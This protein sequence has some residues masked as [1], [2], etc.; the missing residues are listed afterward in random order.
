[1]KA[2]PRSASR[3]LTSAVWP[4]T[5]VAWPG[6][7]LTM[8]CQAPSVLSLV[9]ILPAKG[10]VPEVRSLAWMPSTTTSPAKPLL[11]ACQ[12]ASVLPLAKKKRYLVRSP[13]RM[14]P[15]GPP[16]LPTP[17]GPV[18]QSAGTSTRT[19]FCRSIEAVANTPA[20]TV[21]LFSPAASVTTWLMPV[22]VLASESEA[23]LPR[24]AVV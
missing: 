7:A 16:T 14:P 10:T 18:G 5:A 11:A 20:S 13:S 12:L 17:T 1:M 2:L 21:V 9:M 3:L 24:L 4:V 22:I 6:L 19:V 8:P 15:A 23:S